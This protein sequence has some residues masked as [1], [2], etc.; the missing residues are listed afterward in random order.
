MTWTCVPTYG[1]GYRDLSLPTDSPLPNH[2]RSRVEKGRLLSVSSVPFEL[3]TS[4]LVHVPTQVE[5]RGTWILLYSAK[6]LDFTCIVVRTRLLEGPSRVFG[7]L[8]GH[9]PRLARELG[10]GRGLCGSWVSDRPS[11]VGAQTESSQGF[12]LRPSKLRFFDFC[13]EVRPPVD[14]K[15]SLLFSRHQAYS[16]CSRPPGNVPRLACLQDNLGVESR[17]LPGG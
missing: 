7:W 15:G 16:S 6:D 11:S 14:R 12:G 8:R 9:G 17:G 3:E 5:T 13:L 1:P 10:V 2:L 4:D